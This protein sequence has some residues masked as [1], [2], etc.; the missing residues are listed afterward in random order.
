MDI[1]SKILGSLLGRIHFMIY[2]GKSPAA[3]I[4]V[5]DNDIIVDVSNPLIAL[6]LGLEELLSRK[7][8]QDIK[9]LEN[10]KKAGYRIVI[11]YRGFRLEF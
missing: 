11:K 1:L 7:G 5:K 6:E 9:M 4:E 10:V 3:E 8:E 2:L